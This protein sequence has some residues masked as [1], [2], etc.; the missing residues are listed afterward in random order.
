MQARFVLRG[1][2]MTSTSC[3]RTVLCYM[4]SRL[5]LQVW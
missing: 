5:F 1:T 2:D 3:V 4:R